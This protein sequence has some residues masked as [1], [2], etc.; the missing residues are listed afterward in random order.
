MFHQAEVTRRS[1]LLSKRWDTTIPWTSIQCVV[2]RSSAGGVNTPSYRQLIINPD[3]RRTRLVLS[4][5]IANRDAA[6]AL[7]RLLQNITRR[8]Y[9]S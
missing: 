9:A 8:C 5:A 3:D 1:S 2:W 6:E 4:P 7:V